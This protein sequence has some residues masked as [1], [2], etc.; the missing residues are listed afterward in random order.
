MHWAGGEAN[1]QG[2]DLSSSSKLGHR[3]CSAE[4]ST[5]APSR[6]LFMALLALLAAQALTATEGTFSPRFSSL[7]LRA[8]SHPPSAQWSVSKRSTETEFW[9]SSSC[10]LSSFSPPSAP[11]PI[12]LLLGS[13]WTPPSGREYDCERHRIHS[14]RNHAQ[15]WGQAAFRASSSSSLLHSSVASRGLSLLL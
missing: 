12:P 3:T 8:R 6:P 5:V 14:Q 15:C 13:M 2:I 1:H 10:F 11:G 7:R 4:A 9:T